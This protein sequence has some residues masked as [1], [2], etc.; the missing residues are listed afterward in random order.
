MPFERVSNT[1]NFNVT[2]TGCIIKSTISGW[3]VSPPT[4][5]TT[6]HNVQYTVYHNRCI[7][8]KITRVP[9]GDFDVVFN[10]CFYLSLC[11]IK[12]HMDPEEYVHHVLFIRYT[13]R[14]SY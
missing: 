4:N 3:M 9:R 2:N 8:I 10:A 5:S 1:T 14:A 11:V 6:V 7:C 13:H 12:S